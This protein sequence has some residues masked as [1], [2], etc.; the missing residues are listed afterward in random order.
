MEHMSLI[1][2]F[3]T[4]SA[5]L[6]ASGEGIFRCTETEDINYVKC[7]DVLHREIFK[8]FSCYNLVKTLINSVFVS[9]DERLKEWQL[10]LWSFTTNNGKT[11]FSLKEIPWNEVSSMLCK[12]RLINLSFPHIQ[13]S[14]LSAF[15]GG[16]GKKVKRP[17]KL[18]LLG[19]ASILP[20]QSHPRCTK[21]E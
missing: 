13:V 10:L 11:W 19:K 7:L 15:G 1:T 18:F 12:D 16:R 5:W 8:N 3:Q 4:N 21:T 14:L 17:L 20:S 6:I 9:L 2:H